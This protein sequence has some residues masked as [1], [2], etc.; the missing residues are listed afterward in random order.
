MSSLSDQVVDL[1]EAEARAVACELRRYSD[2]QG[3][4]DIDVAMV[5]ARAELSADPAY[6]YTHEAY[7]RK[8]AEVE[9][10][11]QRLEDQATDAAT[12][13]YQLADDI[14]QS[15]QINLGDAVV[16]GPL[17]EVIDHA[18]WSLDDKYAQPP[19]D[20][21]RVVQATRAADRAAERSRPNGRDATRRALAERIDKSVRDRHAHDHMVSDHSRRPNVGDDLGGRSR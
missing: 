12:P 6:A 17:V 18:G 8:L 19:T 9:Q 15:R 7:E 21:R 13:F 4:F 20:M 10:Q 1:N 3:G 14:E 5:E 16:R 2:M 11:A